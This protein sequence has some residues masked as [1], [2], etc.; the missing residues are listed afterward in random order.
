[1]TTQ[2]EKARIFRDLHIPGSPLI[3][4]NIWDVGS[5]RAVS[6][7]GAQAIA[8]GSWAVAASQGF[9]DGEELP[10]ESAIDLARRLASGI[11]LPVSFDFEGGYAEGGDQLRAN[12]SRLIDTGI[13]GLN[14]E[15]QLVGRPGLYPIDQQSARIRAVRAAAEDAGIQIFINARTDLFLKDPSGLHHEELVLD[16]LEREEAYRAAGADGFFIPGLAAPDLVQAICGK[17]QLP[18]NVMAGNG[19]ADIAGIAKLGVARISFGPAPFLE[20][21]EELRNRSM[22]L[23]S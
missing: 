6:R 10:I 13:V 9:E 22:S 11:E 8:T 23:V 21:M 16:A 3:L 4:Y 7:A 18:V 2:A 1:M 15:D 17:A 5:A 19:S 14:F 12:V 20:L